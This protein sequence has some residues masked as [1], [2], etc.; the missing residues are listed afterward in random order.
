MKK[1]LKFAIL[2]LAAG[3][4]LSYADPGFVYLDN[5][6]STL[7]PLITYGP[8]GDGPLGAGIDNTYTVGL[9]F[10][11]GAFAAS[12]PADPDLLSRSI[13]SSLYVSFILGTGSGSTAQAEY[14][15]VPGT[16]SA[17]IAFQAN[18]VVGG[19]STFMVV[20]YKGSSYDL[21]LFR[22]HSAAFEMTTKAGV[23]LPPAW[24][25]DFMPS[26]QVN[27]APEPSTIAITGLGLVSL[28]FARCRK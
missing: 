5:Y 22:G 19:V 28:L 14:A 25:G 9:Y 4:N 24:I 27:G 26:F 12:V 10:G 8:A 13:P 20:A 3:V 6:L 2:G 17:S 18:S 11:E 21:S 16:F 7:N 23:A 1:S 15:G